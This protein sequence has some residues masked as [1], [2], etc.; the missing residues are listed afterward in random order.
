[1]FP[2]G[3]RFRYRIYLCVVRAD[4]TFSWFLQNFTE[5]DI[6]Y[7][8]SLHFID[9]WLA[10]Y[11]KQD[12]NMRRIELKDPNCMAFYSSHICFLNWAHGLH[13]QSTLCSWNIKVVPP[14]HRES[15]FNR[16]SWFFVFFS[17]G[18][19]LFF[20]NLPVEC[21][22]T[23]STCDTQITRQKHRASCTHILTRRGIG[24]EVINCVFMWR[25]QTII[26]VTQVLYNR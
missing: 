8:V 12:N 24:R 18:Q 17:C 7:L 5:N 2:T 14:G 16:P 22:L 21:W 1:M 13:Y 15:S 10:L 4:T 25:S 6:K 26:I 3:D 23:N 11:L 20:I 19:F 9:C